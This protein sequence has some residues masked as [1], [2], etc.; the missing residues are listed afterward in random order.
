[1]KSKLMVIIPIIAFS[2]LLVMPFNVNA[3]VYSISWSDWDFV[4]PSISKSTYGAGNGSASANTLKAIAGVTPN[5]NPASWLTENATTTI[6]LSSFFKVNGPA[7]EIGKTIPAYLKGNLNGTLVATGFDFG[8]LTGSYSSSVSASV[9]AGFASW[10]NP[11][12]GHSISGGVLIL[13]AISKPVNDVVSVPGTL[14][15]GSTYPFSMSLVVNVNKVGAYQ[16]VS[17]FDNTF[18]ATVEA[19]PEPSSTLLIGLGIIGIGYAKRRK[20]HIEV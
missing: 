6:A 17:K 11:A 9:N 13:D 10:S 16:A 4:S 2:M 20:A 3:S 1:M 15:V 12:D 8:Y 18:F 5:S 19:V 14:T 7:D